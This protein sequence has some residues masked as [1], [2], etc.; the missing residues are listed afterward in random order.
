MKNEAL[1]EYLGKAKAPLDEALL[2]RKRIENRKLRK[3]GEI[4]IS[5]P[6]LADA[7]MQAECGYACVM[8]HAADNTATDH[9]G[10]KAVK[11]SRSLRDCG[12]LL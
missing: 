3:S 1:R 7:V 11:V 10:T 9:Q 5:T 2:R 12:A 8:D 6:Q 4:P